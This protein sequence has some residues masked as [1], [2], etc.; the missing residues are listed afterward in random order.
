MNR[1]AS[2][3]L[4]SSR[5]VTGRNARF[6]QTVAL[7]TAKVAEA[8][9]SSRLGTSLS[10]NRGGCHVLDSAKLDG[11]AFGCGTIR[12]GARSRAARNPSR[13]NHIIPRSSG[14]FARRIFITE[15]RQTERNPQ[16]CLTSRATVPIRCGSKGSVQAVSVNVGFVPTIH[17]A[18]EDK[19]VA[20]CDALS[21]SSTSRRRRVQGHLTPFYSHI[22]GTVASPCHARTLSRFVR[23]NS[24]IFRNDIG[25][26][27][28]C[29]SKANMQS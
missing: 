20:V 4:P 11:L 15:R 8:R 23:T 12:I 7:A 2:G 19:A 22:L 9:H 29:F 27:A 1:G 21:S 24:R 17:I 3:F 16:R 13:A 26:L 5:S 10:E 25:R 6:R 14:C 28:C 18:A